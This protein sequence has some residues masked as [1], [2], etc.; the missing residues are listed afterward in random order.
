QDFV[1][2]TH[3]IQSHSKA[4]QYLNIVLKS[5]DEL[6]TETA[7]K[8]ISATQKGQSLPI[9]IDKELSTPTEFKFVIDSITR[10]D[11]DSK[12]L[13]NYDGKSAGVDQKD[14]LEYEIAGRDSF[15][16][17]NVQVP[18]GDNRTLLINFSDPV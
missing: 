3:D 9:K 4:K 16:V 1:I 10:Y 7:S 14:Q 11:A 15:K 6:Q 2:N 18:D 12:I 13:I 8:I 17:V 5:A